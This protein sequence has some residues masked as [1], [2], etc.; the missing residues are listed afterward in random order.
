MSKI[1]DQTINREY[2]GKKDKIRKKSKIAGIALSTCLATCFL[3]VVLVNENETF[4]KSVS[5]IPVIKEL[6]KLVTIEKIVEEDNEKL[7]YANIPAIQ[8]TGNTDLE[9][10]IKL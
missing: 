8:N 3:F 4:A 5:K 6:A 2:I 7:V 1:V 9:K 10:R